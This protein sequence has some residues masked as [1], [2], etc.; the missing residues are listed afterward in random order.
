MRNAPF[1][2]EAASNDSPQ[3]AEG[4]PGDDKVSA[5]LYDALVKEVFS[6]R[7]ASL[8]RENLL[9][10]KESTNEVSWAFTRLCLSPGARLDFLLFL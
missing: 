1:D 7:K 8:D 10:D 5:V 9:K 6:L 3:V 2:E 4:Q